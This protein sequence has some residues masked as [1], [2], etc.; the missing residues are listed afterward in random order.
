M[1]ICF[2]LDTSASMNIMFGSITYLDVC[3]AAIEQFISCDTRSTMNQYMLVTYDDSAL[4]V[5]GNGKELI[6][7]L[8]LVQARGRSEAGRS[9]RALFDHLSIIRTTEFKDMNGNGR[10]VSDQ[11]ST[12]IFWLTDAMEFSDEKGV[13][14][15]LNIPG[16][17]TVGMDM[18]LE[19][20]R[21]EQRLVTIAVRRPKNELIRTL[22]DHMNGQ[23]WVVDTIKMLLLCMQNCHGTS[24]T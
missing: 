17:K 22:S 6:E 10:F 23:F 20:F 9:L 21:W 11:E 5:V 18:Y 16:G 14:E 13:T 24:D 2:L 1:L 8:K 15:K 12:L 4:R 19:P 3:K 7:E